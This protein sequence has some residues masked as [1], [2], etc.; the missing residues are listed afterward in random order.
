MVKVRREEREVRGG[1]KV[2]AGKNR[3]FYGVQRFL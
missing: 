3:M 1:I 2:Y